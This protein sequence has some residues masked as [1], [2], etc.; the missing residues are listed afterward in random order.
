MCDKGRKDKGSW[1]DRSGHG[2]YA[3]YGGGFGGMAVAMYMVA[4]E[5]ADGWMEA[6]EQGQEN[7]ARF[8]KASD[9]L[10]EL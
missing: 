3:S 4:T 7:N 5:I 1:Y 8:R 9:A 10:Q 6:H 2:S